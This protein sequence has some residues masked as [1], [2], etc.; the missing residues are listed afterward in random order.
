[1]RIAMFGVKGFPAH[2]GDQ[3]FIELGRR[4]VKRGHEVIIYIRPHYTK[5]KINEY[6]GIKFVLTKGIHSKHLDAITYT[7]TA[8]IDSLGRKIDIF[9]F[10][11]I[12]L[13]IFSFI[14]RLIGKISVVHNVGLDWKRA[15]WGSFAKLFLKITDYSTLFFPNLTFAISKD[16][17]NYYQSK[18]KRKVLWLP[19]GVNCKEHSQPEEICRYGLN[20]EDYILYVSRLVPEKGCHYLLEAYEGIMTDKKLVIAGDASV[21]DDYYHSLLKRGNE[22]IIFTGYVTGKLLDELYSNAYLFVQPSE[23]EGLPH[24]VL[25]ALSFGRCVL[26]SDIPGN[27]EAL[28]E[29]GVT[30]KNKDSRDLKE[31]LEYLLANP[32]MITSQKKKSIH[33]VKENYDWEKIIDNLENHFFGLLKRG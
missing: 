3:F 31:K 22:R 12:G 20:K 19:T 15:K 29:C 33:H 30:F 2:G 10:Y 25:Q 9:Y 23:I 6:E 18:F 26:A 16:D 24:S 13:S 27:R 8:L 32:D 17:V 21:H 14:P 11:S 7:A 4:L 28:G 5:R 1:M